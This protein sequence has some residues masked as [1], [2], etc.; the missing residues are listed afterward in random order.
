MNN[1][2]TDKNL[3]QIDPIES[4]ANHVIGTATADGMIIRGRLIKFDERVIWLEKMSG[5]VVMIARAGI[6]RI[7]RSHDCK[8]DSQ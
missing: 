6:E 2:S 1:I 3:S 7:W 8:R 5:D 4:L